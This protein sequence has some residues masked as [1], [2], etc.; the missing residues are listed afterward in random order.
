MHACL[1]K[2]L[3]LGSFRALCV[4]ASKARTQL[5]SRL[6]FECVTLTIMAVLLCA[7]RSSYHSGRF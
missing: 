6:K 3:R 2:V 1:P 5:A 7:L 4:T